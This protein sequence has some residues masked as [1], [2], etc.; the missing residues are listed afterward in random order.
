MSIT[1]SLLLGKV[2]LL[3]DNDLQRTIF[4]G[5]SIVNVDIPNGRLYLREPKP[6]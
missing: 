3:V 6:E 1:I 4:V 2:N 5:L